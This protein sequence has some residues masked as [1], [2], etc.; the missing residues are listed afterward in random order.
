MGDKALEFF[1]DPID[2]FDAVV[3]EVDL[4]I[5]GKFAEDGIFNEGLFP[6]H[7]EGADGEAVL[8]R[9]VDHREFAR[10]NKGEVE[11]AGNGGGR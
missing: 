1:T 4:S 6:F 5:A 8:G 7:K 9:G 10:A 3:D 2:G 11:G